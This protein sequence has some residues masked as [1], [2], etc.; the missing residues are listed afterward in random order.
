MNFEMRKP[1]VVQKIYRGTIYI[2]D[3]MST[4]ITYSQLHV[5]KYEVAEA[6]LTVIKQVC[7]KKRKYENA[8][9][10]PPILRGTILYMYANPAKDFVFSMVIKNFSIVSFLQRFFKINM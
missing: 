10:M 2:T 3:V 1:R 9:E 5:Y 4:V 8:S 7:P 6:S